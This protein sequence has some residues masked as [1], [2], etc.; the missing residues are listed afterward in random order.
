[1][2]KCRFISEVEHNF[3]DKN[4]VFYYKYES[5]SFYYPF[6]IYDV[7]TKQEVGLFNNTEFN[8]L[9]VDIKLERKEKLNKIYESR[10]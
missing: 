4:E 9:F 6:H 7:S 10:R 3:Y 2:R 5:N 8:S 1:M